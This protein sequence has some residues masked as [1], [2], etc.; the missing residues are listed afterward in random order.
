[1]AESCGLSTRSGCSG[2]RSWCCITGCTVRIDGSPA[3]RWSGNAQVNSVL[4]RLEVLDEAVDEL[5]ERL[6]PGRGPDH[7]LA[8]PGLDVLLDHPTRA[9]PAGRDQQLRI[10]VRAA[11]ADRCYLRVGDVAVQGDRNAEAE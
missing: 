2:S 1:M 4:E 6:E 5:A 7:E 11:A 9:V 10:R 8:Q 3:A